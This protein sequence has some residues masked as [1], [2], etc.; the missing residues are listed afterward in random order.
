MRSL[1]STVAREFKLLFRNGIT[2]YLVAAPALLSVVFILV[3]GSVQRASVAFAV[4]AS[5][6]REIAVRLE[7]VADL[8]YFD[9]RD[10]LIRRVGGT[11]SLAGIYME[12]GRVR[13]VVEGNEPE[14]FADSRRS[15]VGAALGSEAAAYT[16]EPVEGKNSLAYELSTAAI[17]LLALFIGG[18][19]EGLGG[20]AERESGVIKA[21]F[22]SPMTLF[23]YILSKLIPALLFGLLSVAVCSVIMG[24]FTALLQH[25]LMAAASVFVCGIIAFV[26][27]AFADNQI[28][29][30]GVLKIIMPLFLVVGLSAAFIPE[31][32]LPA[33][34]ALP[35]Y[36]QYAA[37]RAI[38][39]GGPAFFP[40]LMIVLT[41]L[42]WFAVVMVIFSKRMN[43]KVRR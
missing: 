10:S 2:I 35:M 21:I 27:I 37:I 23:G 34:Y 14:G 3:F 17:F 30:V 20:V 15:L 41:A 4:D 42:P 26:L 1:F 6:P 36:W 33:C 13:L 8:E 22:V 31:K 7:T 28:A 43:L 16:S 25:M 29:A 19:T 38:G 32:L 40:T 5:V 18:A 12:D 11:D 24:G 9:D 39:E